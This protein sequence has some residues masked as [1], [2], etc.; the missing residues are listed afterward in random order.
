MSYDDLR[1]GRVSLPGYAYFLTTVTV[2]REPV[3]G[4]LYC[5]RL[6]ITEMRALHDAGNL[7][8]LAFVVMPDHVHWLV[9][10]R[11]E[12]LLEEVMR[13]FKGRSA[14]MIN[15]Y[16]GRRGSLWQ[17]AFHDRAIRN[18]EDIRAAA[19][20]LVANPLRAGLVRDIADYP[21]WDAVWLD[22]GGNV[23]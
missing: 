19:R 11:D 21:H 2:A 18:T 17:R 22:A 12:T 5:A 14:R 7:R 23:W 4:D 10:L 15:R 6:A 1:R 9:Q 20:Y 3:F 8:S 13:T 16:R